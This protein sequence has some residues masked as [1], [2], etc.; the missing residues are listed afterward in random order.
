MLQ[1]KISDCVPHKDPLERPDYI[2]AEIQAVRAVWR[3]EADG[4]QQRM[5]LDF[6]VRAFGTHDTSHRP[7]D[8]YGTAFAEGK[9]NAGTTIVWAVNSAPTRTDPDKIATRKLEDDSDARPDNRT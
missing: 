7:G 6:F 8:P 1:K 5:V 2:E 4:R 9:R 3:G